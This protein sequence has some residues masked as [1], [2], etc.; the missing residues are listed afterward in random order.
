MR[1]LLFCSFLIVMACGEPQQ[2]P[3]Q[4]VDVRV[5]IPEADPNSIDF[6]TVEQVIGANEDKMFCSELMYEGE[7]AAFT[8]VTSLQGKF[9]HH[10][11]LVSTTA[12]Q[13]VGTNYDCTEMRD[14]LPLA[15]PANPKDG[16]PAAHGSSLRKNTPVVIQMHYVNTSSRPILV[17]DVIRLK[18]IDVAQV[19][20]WMAPFA[21]NHETFNV[22]SGHAD[23]V[24]FDCVM[25]ADFKMLLVGG[26]MHENGTSFKIE[27]GSSTSMEKLYEVTQWQALFRDSPPVTLFFSEPKQVTKGS[28]MRTTCAW[29]N[30]TDHALNYPHEMCATFGLFAGTKDSFICRKSQ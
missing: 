29:N 21:L 28:I 1:T 4:P 22:A 2:P 12:P 24:T 10:V 15:I 26:H 5:A 11:I 7:D 6:V 13:G 23:S 9:G 20:T 27:L 16:W 14:F 30:K 3:V 18:K 19:T 25:P 17:R 8:E